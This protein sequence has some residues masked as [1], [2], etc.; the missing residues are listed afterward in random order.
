[1]EKAYYYNDGGTVV[2]ITPITTL[3]IIL[4]HQICQTMMTTCVDANKMN[5]QSVIS[6]LEVLRGEL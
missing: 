2:V 5:M 4:K 6:K 1:M 3:Y